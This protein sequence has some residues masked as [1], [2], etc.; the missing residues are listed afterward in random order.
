M[1][2]VYEMGQAGSPKKKSKKSLKIIG[3]IIAVILA[4]ALG[5]GIAYAVAPRDVLQL[6]MNKQSY[7]KLTVG[8]NISELEGASDILEELTQAKYKEQ[9]ESDMNLSLSPKITEK[10]SADPSIS[11]LISYVNTLKIKGTQSKD[12]FLSKADM[13]IYDNAGKLI[14][15]STIS[16]DAAIAFLEYKNMDAIESDDDAKLIEGGAYFKINTINSGWLAPSKSGLIP[17]DVSGVVKA[18][19]KNKDLDEQFSKGSKKVVKTFLNSC[20]NDNVKAVESGKELKVENT[21][22]K[23][24]KVTFT[25]TPEE[26]SK[27][28]SAALKVA[29]DDPDLYK[30]FKSLYDS[31]VKANP[32]IIAKLNLKDITMDKDGY[33]KY[34]DLMDIKI[35]EYCKNAD[36]KAIDISFYIDKKNQI[37]G[38]DV[39][40]NSK[41]SDDDK[42]IYLF[43]FPEVK[44]SRDF[45]MKYTCGKK[46]IVVEVKHISEKSANTK[47]LIMDDSDG[48]CIDLSGTY[49]NVKIEDGVLYGEISQS[50]NLNLTD[51]NTAP[52]K[53][54]GTIS[55]KSENRAGKHTIKMIIEDEMLGRITTNYTAT[56]LKFEPITIP[57]AGT[58]LDMSSQS[59]ADKAKLEE[60]TT[61]GTEYIFSDLAKNHPDLGSVIQA[62]FMSAL[63]SEDGAGL[64][65]GI[66][67]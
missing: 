42:E 6:V 60:L 53:S 20:F 59:D 61:K 48:F 67:A 5:L 19:G 57:E 28:V 3:I 2:G 49:K 25:L 44:D 66:T 37:V 17:G 65:G 4:I 51:E 24:D 9:Y 64:L 36:W 34:I 29:K 40:I 22:V 26:L 56:K 18:V 33:K 58:V 8:K 63:K 31:A 35:S 50:F 46:S 10:I 45:V 54:T 32:Q 16:D 39:V 11:A 15:I 13:A 7:A 12:G 30:A 21:T 41:D 62:V 52:L 47:V 43:A 23:G 55:V 38:A 27:S 14:D 1:S